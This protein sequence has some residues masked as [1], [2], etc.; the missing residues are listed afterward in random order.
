[1]LL[2]QAVG[3]RRARELSITGNFL[4]AATALEWGLVNHVV[5]HEEL[6]P[7]ARRLALDVVSNDQRAVRRLL[8]TYADGSLATAQDAWL[9]EAD[10]AE[11]WTAGID[12]DGF[13]QRR[14]DVMDRGRA[15][16]AQQT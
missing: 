8:E 12:P 16:S 1:V 2:P 5:P 14:R 6:L 10:V 11:A 4:D 7:F 9:L 15:Q 3:V 13:D